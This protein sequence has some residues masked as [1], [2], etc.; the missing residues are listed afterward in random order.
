MLETKLQTKKK[1]G[2]RNKMLVGMMFLAFLLGGAVVAAFWGFLFKDDANVS[3]NRNPDTVQNP[4]ATAPPTTRAPVPTVPPQ[5]TT[6]SPTVSPAPT[7]APTT[8]RDGMFQKLFDDHGP[9]WEDAIKWLSETDLY[10]SQ[11]VSELKERYALAALFYRTSG[12][13][14][15]NFKQDWLSSNSVCDGWYGVSCNS[16]GKV[17]KIEFVDN[18]LV[19]SLPSEIGM[20]TAL[21]Y[22]KINDS[23][24]LTG[25]IPSHI[26]SLTNLE[27]FSLTHCYITGTV[28]AEITNLRSLKTLEFENNVV[29]GSLP[30]N[31]NR[32]TNLEYFLAGGNELAGSIPEIS[33]LTNLRT[34]ELDRNKLDSNLP[35]LINLTNLETLDLKTNRLVGSV[36][37]LPD[38]IVD[39]DLDWNSFMNTDNGVSKG[40]FD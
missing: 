13:R 5:P 38:S 11:N 40:C 25:S 27:L 20:L 28:P 14:L 2:S 1:G 21:T 15:W 24:E 26:S 10:E 34:F 36:P 3:T 8:R 23:F 19:G 32:L 4:T 29:S 31:M 22:L 35:E 6:P 18:S 37:I 30:S 12:A 16:Q 39:C 9:L 33:A 17:T 7:G